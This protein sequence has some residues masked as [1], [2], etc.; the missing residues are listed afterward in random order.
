MKNYSLSTSQTTIWANYQRLRL[1]LSERLNRELTQKTGLSEADFEIL[2]A[3][4]ET[5][6][7]T[8]RAL[9]LRCG[10]E[11]EKSRLSHQL[12]R[13]EVRGLITREEC[14]EDN[15]GSVIRVTDVGRKLAAEAKLHYEEAVRYYVMDVLSPEQLEALGSIAETILAQLEEPHNHKTR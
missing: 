2:T 1:R 3:L 7:E 4:T 9:I 11:W 14:V 6:D 15:R 13:M 10:L 12:K 8:V 5:S